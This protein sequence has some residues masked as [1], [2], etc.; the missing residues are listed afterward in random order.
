M[1]DVKRS[2]VVAVLDDMFFSS[3]IKEAAKS[4]G[5]N[6]EILKNTNGLIEALTSSPPSLIIVDLNFKKL[7]PLEFIGELKSSADLKNVPTLGYL[8]HVERELKKEAIK[9]G[10][11][12]VMPRSRFVREIRDILNKGSY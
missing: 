12:F 5:A 2:R 10:Y 7:I 11:D 3:K 1:A 9:A 4:T 6:V 8:P